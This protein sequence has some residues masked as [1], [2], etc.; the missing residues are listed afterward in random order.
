MPQPRRRTDERLVAENRSFVAFVPF[1]ARW[2]GE[3][4]VCARRHFGGIAE[5]SDRE[6]SD[7]ANLIKMA[8][9]KY[10]NLY[11]FPMPLMMLVR[12]APAKGEHRYFHFHVD[13][14]PIQRSAT[15]LKYLAA[16]E[17]G[18]G[19]FL[20]DTVAEQKARELREAEP[21]G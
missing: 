11:G 13:F 6:A 10:D 16:V 17:S 20:N 3:M 1:F 8:R 2:P 12:Q 18:S 14:C 15:K 7:L 21:R 9:M 5:L 4:Q 19:M